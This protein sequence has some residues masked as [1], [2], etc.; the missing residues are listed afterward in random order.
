MVSGSDSH[1]A[2]VELKAEELGKKPADFAKESHEL[3]VDIYRQLGLVYENYTKTTTD[4]HKEVAQNVFTVLRENGYL[5]V[6]KSKQYF[7]PKANRFLPDRYVRGTCPN[8]GNKNARGDECPECGKFLQPEDLVDPYSAISDAIPE[9]RETEHF[10][11]NL[12]ALS[13]RLGEWIGNN[14]EHWRTWVREFSLGWI[15]QGLEE[16]AVTRDMKWGVAV[17]LKGWEEKVIYVWIE[18]LVGYLSAAIE[19][20]DFIGEPSRWEDFWK[21]PEAKH[22]YFVAGGN[23]PFHTIM[24]PGEIIAYNEKYDND[25]KWEK[26]KLPGESKRE[27]LNLPY[28]VPAN[29]MLTHKGK[30]MSKGDGVGMTVEKLLADYSPDLIR[31]FFIR[32]APENHNREFSFKDFIDANNNELVGNLGNFINRVIAFTNSKF[33]GVVPD[34]EL[35]EEVSKEIDKAFSNIG[36]FIEKCQFVKASKALLKF[37]D[38]ANK[39]FNDMKPWELIKTDPKAAGEVLYN[40]IQIVA[41]LR[42][43]INPF[44]PFSTVKISKLL[45]LENIADPTDEVATNRVVA[46]PKDLWNF[47]QVDAGHKIN[48]AEVLFEKLEYT[49]ELALMDGEK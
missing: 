29:N 3:I 41:A 33:D 2:P 37:G 10:Y 26:Y 42:M 28:D 32:F 35:S 22:Y 30:K 20:A 1:G 38:F 18:A 36:K 7:D 6:K 44:I 40:C 48:K 45:N 5:T 21:N 16:R 15:K 46:Q 27:H 11:M 4:L 39:Y 25:E 49:D 31:Y 17:P 19:W 47:D 14:S 23:V 43:L 9:L 12:T 8:C 34:G 24:W 13:D